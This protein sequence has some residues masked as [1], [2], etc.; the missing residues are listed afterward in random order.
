[1]NRLSR[2]LLIV[3]LALAIGAGAFLFL[4]Q[5]SRAKS[6]TLHGHSTYYQDEEECINPLKKPNAL[7]LWGE[8]QVFDECSEKVI[9][10]CQTNTY[11]NAT[12]SFATTCEDIQFWYYTEDDQWWSIGIALDVP[13]DKDDYS[14][15]VKTSST[16]YCGC[17]TH[18]GYWY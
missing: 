1:M 9:K 18:S 2:V 6:I 4:A 3:T 16:K 14:Y 7:Y 5:P 17:W 15:T 12:C 8:F 13:E 11:G 10:T